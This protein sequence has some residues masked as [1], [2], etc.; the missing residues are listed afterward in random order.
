MRLIGL[1]GGSGSG[2][3]TVSGVFKS[4]GVPCFDCDAIYHRM[5]SRDST[6]CREIVNCFGSSVRKEN[7]GIDRRALAAMVYDDPEKKR[8]LDL[9]THRRILKVCGDWIRYRRRKGYSAAVIDAPLL[10]ESG[11]DRKCDITLAVIAPL[12]LRL[13]RIVERDGITP[14]EA[15]KRIAMQIPDDELIRRADRVIRNDGDVAT[16]ETKV[17]KLM[18]SINEGST[19]K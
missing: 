3:G 6:L 7:G 17:L 5:I 8:L 15:K 11:L 2:K 18:E 12:E 10:F 16:L 19:S 13:S 9:I 14:E 1:A 4:A